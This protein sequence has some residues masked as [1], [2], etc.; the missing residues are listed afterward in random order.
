MFK[1]LDYSKIHLCSVYNSFGTYDIIAIED[2]FL[3]GPPRRAVVERVN[4]IRRTGLV[5]RDIR[6]LRVYSNY[7]FKVFIHS[8]LVTFFIGYIDLIIQL[9]LFQIFDNPKFSACKIEE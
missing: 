6:H 1:I 9:F 8:S 3:I 5:K 2:K 7:F 4:M